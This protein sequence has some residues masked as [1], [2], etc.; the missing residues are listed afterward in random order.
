L[1]NKSWNQADLCRSG[2]TTNLPRIAAPLFSLAACGL[3][4]F[5]LH[6]LSLNL[7]YHALIHALR[8]IRPKLV[9]TSIGWTA[10]S[11]LALI[12]SDTCALTYAGV[13]VPAQGLLLASF[14]GWALDNTAGFGALTGRAVRGRVYGALGVRP[15]PIARIMLFIYVAFGAGLA[16]FAGANALLAGGGRNFF[17][18]P[19]TLLHIAGAILIIIV[20]ASLLTCVRRRSPFVIGRLAFIVPSSR[21]AFVQLLISV[22]DLL[23]AAMALWSLLPAD[24]IDFFTFGAIFSVANALGVLSRIPGGLGIFEAVVLFASQ[25]HLAPNHTAAALV[26]YRGVY[27]LL[28][29][30][31]ASACLAGFELRRLAGRPAS[32]IGQRMRVAVN[33]LAPSF[34]SVV[35]FSIGT[36]LIVSGA[37]PA[38]HWRLAVLQGLLPLWAVEISHL[39]A[40]LAGVFLLF[41]ARGLYHR[42][43]GAR[44][45]ALIIAS[46]SCCLV[47]REGVG[48]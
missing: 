33:L 46:A 7:D 38:V 29:L 40:T 19:F 3:A 42:L 35:T 18:P 21:L 12:A 27:F 11:Y 24:A 48:L 28:P 44:W 14:C 39:L 4:L 20:A 36:M 16:A 9:W 8:R 2:S 10:L 5:V 6:R 15:E 22:I 17:S 45:L 37:T 30:L 43:D 41:I 32:T 23:G 25:G 47:P 1:V 34:L 26:A 31:F 13:N